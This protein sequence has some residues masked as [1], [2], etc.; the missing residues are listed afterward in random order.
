MHTAYPRNSRWDK[1]E[2]IVRKINVKRYTA[3]EPRI[4]LKKSLYFIWIARK[5]H[6]SIITVVFHF[7]NYRIDRFITEKATTVIDQRTSLQTFLQDLH[8]HLYQQALWK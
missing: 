4:F 3:V 2:V 5:Y 1:S 8:V 6:N 7:L